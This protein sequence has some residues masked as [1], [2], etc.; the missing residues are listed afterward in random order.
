MLECKQEEIRENNYESKRRG[1]VSDYYSGRKNPANISM[2][3]QKSHQEE[4]IPKRQETGKAL[5]HTGN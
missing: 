1:K 3:S 5:A 2:A 4:Q